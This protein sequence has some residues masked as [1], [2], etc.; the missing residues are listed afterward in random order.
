MMH[1]GDVALCQHMKAFQK[2]SLIGHD[3]RGISDTHNMVLVLA[4]M[5][6]EEAHSGAA[7]PTASRERRGALPKAVSTSEKH[8]GAAELNRGHA[9]PTGST[10]RK[11]VVPKEEPTGEKPSGN[12]EPDGPTERT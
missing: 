11:R 6:V 2:S 8:K 4:K 12:A 1:R 5:Y 7:E 10:K 3:Y 9:E